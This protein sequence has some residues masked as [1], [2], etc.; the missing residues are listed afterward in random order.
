MKKSEKAAKAASLI[1]KTE[2]KS[3]VPDKA[4]LNEGLLD[5][6]TANMA[7]TLAAPTKPTAKPQDG[8]ATESLE[9]LMQKFAG[10]DGQDDQ[11]LTDSIIREVEASDREQARAAA[12][13]ST[14]EVAH[15]A[16]SHHEQQAE[17]TQQTALVKQAPKEKAP[18]AK[19]SAPSKP[20]QLAPTEQKASKVKPTIP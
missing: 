8:V 7:S 11:A 1:Q 3:E 17:K 16:G 18:I 2:P 20:A 13:K 15:A 12:K 6:V 5:A 10:S 19:V 9:E 14:P 4:V